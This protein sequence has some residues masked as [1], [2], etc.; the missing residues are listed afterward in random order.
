MGQVPESCQSPNYPIYHWGECTQA[1]HILYTSPA[2]F[3]RS[4]A[5]WVSQEYSVQAT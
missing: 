2:H 1:A 5:V 3:A 4:V